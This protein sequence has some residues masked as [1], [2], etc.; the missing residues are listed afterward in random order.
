M[1]GSMRAPSTAL[2]QDCSSGFDGVDDRAT[3]RPCA[4]SL[5]AVADSTCLAFRGRLGCSRKAEPS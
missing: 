2:C 1:A 3:A 5:V 4:E